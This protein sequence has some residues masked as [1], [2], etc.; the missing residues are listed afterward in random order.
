EPERHPATRHPQ[1]EAMAG[2]DDDP[3]VGRAWNRRGTTRLPSREGA[4]TDERPAFSTLPESGGSGTGVEGRVV[5][6]FTPPR[7]HEVQQAK[8]HPPSRRDVRVTRTSSPDSRRDVRVTRTSSSDSRREV[9]VTRTS[10]PDSGRDVWVTRT[11][12]SD[13]RRDVWVTRTSSPDS[14]RDVWVTRTSSSDAGQEIRSAPP[15][16]TRR[17]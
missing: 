4:R 7:L 14:R 2:R 5:C 11:S 16:G 12:A 8:G 10:S 1:R 3:A 6:L 15:G 17:R 13:S 9:R